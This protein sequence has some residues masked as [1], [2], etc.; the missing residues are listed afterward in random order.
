MQ[1]LKELLSS[2]KGYKY[3]YEVVKGRNQ[4]KTQIWRKSI[5]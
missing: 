3:G 1:N 5:K 4:A 2:K